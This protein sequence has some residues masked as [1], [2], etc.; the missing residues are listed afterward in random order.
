MVNMVDL[1]VYYSLYSR[2]RL[3]FLG[4][5]RS[6]FLSDK[7]H[8]MR[9]LLMRCIERTFGAAEMSHDVTWLNR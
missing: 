9:Y 4:V 6:R 7:Q 3:E 8:Q 1:I 2:S 5:T